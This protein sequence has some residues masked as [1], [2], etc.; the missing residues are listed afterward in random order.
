M[1]DELACSHDRE[2]WPSIVSW[3]GAE[4]D[5]QREGRICFEQL[6]GRIEPRRRGSSLCVLARRIVDD[7]R[8]GVHSDYIRRSRALEFSEAHEVPLLED[9]ELQRALAK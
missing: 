9:P 6:G 7:V 5:T 8:S 3:Q 4:K 2:H 1:S